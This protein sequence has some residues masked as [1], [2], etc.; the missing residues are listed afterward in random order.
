MSL[1]PEDLVV[2]GNMLMTLL[3]PVCRNNLFGMTCKAKLAVGHV[4]YWINSQL[5]LLPSFLSTG[6]ECAVYPSLGKSMGPS[7][8]QSHN[9]HIELLGPAGLLVVCHLLFFPSTWHA[10]VLLWDNADKSEMSILVIIHD[11]N[12]VTG[13][14]NSSS[15]LSDTGQWI[16]AFPVSVTTAS[17]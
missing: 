17:M 7:G 10:K 6:T 16:I 12:Y 5:F 14:F 2:G 1:S 9:W 11:C 13:C 3:M 4:D 15:M 8:W